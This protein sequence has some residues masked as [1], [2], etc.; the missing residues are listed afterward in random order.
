MHLVNINRCAFLGLINI[1]MIKYKSNMT[2]LISKLTSINFL[3]DFYHIHNH[4]VLF[5]Y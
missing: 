5:Y 3:P 2:D 1:C 4:D